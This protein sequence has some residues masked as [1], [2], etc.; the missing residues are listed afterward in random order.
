MSRSRQ[1]QAPAAAQESLLP[2][3]CGWAPLPLLSS[4][5][6]QG[7]GQ[8]VQE[9]RGLGLDDLWRSPLPQT[10]SASPGGEDWMELLPSAMARGGKLEQEASPGQQPLWDRSMP[11]ARLW[12]AGELEN[13]GG[14]HRAGQEPGGTV[15]KAQSSTQ[16]CAAPREEGLRV[17]PWCCC[18]ALQLG[19]CF[20]SSS[21]VPSPCPCAVPRC[22]WALEYTQK[23]SC[24]A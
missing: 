9:S 19:L 3:G 7:S 10:I 1:K 13:S 5:A 6:S 24:S 2:W 12:A 15:G 4:G 8:P 14:S 16:S 20:Q 17:V 23:G 22:C 21:R 11:T 18:P